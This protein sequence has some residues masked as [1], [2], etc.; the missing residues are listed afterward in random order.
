ME[1]MLAVLAVAAGLLTGCSQTTV[2]TEWKDPGYTGPAVRSVAVLCLPVDSKEKECED[3]FVRQFERE[4][5][6]ATPAYRMDMEKAKKDSVMAKARKMGIHRVLVSRF[7]R[8]K[9]ELDVYHREPSMILMP[10]YDMWSDYDFVENQYQVFGTMLYDVDTGKAIW[11]ALSDTY[12][13]STE[14][15][16]MESYTKAMVKKMEKKGL[17]AR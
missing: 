13:H 9:S 11:S 1:K 6:S 3:G 4:S 10:D 16:S 7:L 2:Q 14:E 5:I 15:K 8:N 17:L 12:V